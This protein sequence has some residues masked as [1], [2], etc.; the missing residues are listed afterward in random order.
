M[1]NCSQ[2]PSLSITGTVDYCTA[3]A[4]CPLPLS[5]TL[6]EVTAFE[7]SNPTITGGGSLVLTPGTAPANFLWITTIQPVRMVINGGADF[8]PI[9]RLHILT[10]DV[11]TIEIFN[12]VVT[13]AKDVQ[14]SVVF[15]SGTYL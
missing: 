8:I 1:A 13:I 6:S 4:S 5:L 12:D 11:T 15:A 9:E 14:I 7:P 10:G 2:A 3:T